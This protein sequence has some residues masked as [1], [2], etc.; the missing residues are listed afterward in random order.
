MWPRNSNCF[1]FVQES[2]HEFAAQSGQSVWPAAEMLCRYFASLPSL[3][4]LGDGIL[5]LG[6]GV[7]LPSVYLSKRMRGLG[8]CPKTLI[9]DASIALCDIV[10]RNI[11][12]NDLQHVTLKPVIWGELGVR[13]LDVALDAAGMSVSTIIATDTFHRYIE[14]WFDCYC[15]CSARN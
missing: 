6:A 1:H 7:G 5:E 14:Y 2:G 10:K 9:T 4:F 12:K 3:V 13:E 15:G 8:L 11:I